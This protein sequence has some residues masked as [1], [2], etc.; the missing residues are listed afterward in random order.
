MGAIAITVTDNLYT[1]QLDQYDWTGLTVNGQAIQQVNGGYT[2]I[3][4]SEGPVDFS[5]TSDVITT[6]NPGDNVF[7][8]ESGEASNSHLALITYTPPSTAFEMYGVL[9]NVDTPPN[10]QAGPFTFNQGMMTGSF[11]QG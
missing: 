6:V 1:I 8:M 11:A 5:A 7:F 4:S 2:Y 3:Q 10:P 9:C